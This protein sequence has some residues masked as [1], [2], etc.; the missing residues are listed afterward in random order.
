MKRQ[1]NEK[2][3]AFVR[4]LPCLVCPDDTTTEAAHVRFHDFRAD[5]RS[6]GIGEKSDDRWAV[7]LCGAHHRAQHEMNEREFWSVVKIDPVFIALALW[8]VTGDHAAG[9]RIVGANRP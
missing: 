7:P 3:L 8:S 5:K 1:N 2:H 6:V 4:G 9:Q